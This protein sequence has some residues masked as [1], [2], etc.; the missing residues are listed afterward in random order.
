MAHGGSSMAGCSCSLFPVGG[1][2]NS[3]QA[4]RQGE[5]EGGH[6]QGDFSGCPLLSTYLH[7]NRAAQL[8]KLS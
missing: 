5:T 4:S 7:P 1:G 2:G 8:G 6:P 3:Q